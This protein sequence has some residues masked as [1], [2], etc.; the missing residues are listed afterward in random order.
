MTE[1]FLNFILNIFGQQGT[2]GIIGTIIGATLTGI[3]THFQI[4]KKVKLEYKYLYYQNLIKMLDSF[5]EN[6]MA[7]SSLEYNE[8]S[9]R[10][11]MGK[12]L[13]NKNLS[14]LRNSYPL[15]TKQ[16]WELVGTFYRLHY[17]FSNKKELIKKH[18]TII[19]YIKEQNYK[20]NI[21]IYKEA[22][23]SKHV[24]QALL[25]YEIS[26]ELES[27]TKVLNNAK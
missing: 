3:I 5:L 23:I 4:T 15:S 27:I 16:F 1:I 25:F 2:A 14:E 21:E 11:E 9:I 19:N 10:E 8:L 24:F 7:M 17:I 13:S 18:N 12:L 6:K 20:D 22:I 26:Q